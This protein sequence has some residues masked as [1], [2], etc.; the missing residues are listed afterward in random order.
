MLRVAVWAGILS[1]VGV[2]GRGLVKGRWPEEDR[3]SRWLWTFGWICMC[4]HVFLAF[5]M[6]H[7]WSH[8]DAY[9]VTAKRTRETTGLDWGGG[10]WF[11]YVFLAGWG[12]D[13]ARLGFGKAQHTTFVKYWR[14][15]LHGFLAFLIFN[16]VV[17]FETGW[18]RLAGLALTMT[19]VTLAVRFGPARWTRNRCPADGTDDRLGSHSV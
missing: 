5:A 16:S 19:L 4:G 8:A 14:I 6:V 13:V 7:H 1:Y 3:L 9:E 10:V 2:I 17:V 12:A 15:V 11:N 18:T